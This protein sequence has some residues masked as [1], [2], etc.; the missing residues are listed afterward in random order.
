MLIAVFAKGKEVSDIIFAASVFWHEVFDSYLLNKKF[1]SAAGAYA[2]CLLEN[3]FF[4]NRFLVFDAFHAGFSY[5][6]CVKSQT[7]NNSLI[8]LKL[9][10]YKSH[11]FI[12]IRKYS[13]A[14]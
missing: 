13:F 12:K 5:A 4:K 1:S 9:T 10:S 6:K 11:N 14:V 2:V 8:R 3:D 7:K